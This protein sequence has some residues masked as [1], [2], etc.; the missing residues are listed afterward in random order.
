MSPL[1]ERVDPPWTSPEYAL[2]QIH[3]RLQVNG[4]LQTS[5]ADVYAI[6]DIAAFPNPRYGGKVGRQEHVQNARESAKHAVT[7]IM[8]PEEA[9]DYDYLPVRLRV[10]VD[11]LAP[12]NYPIPSCILVEWI[13]DAC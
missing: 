10:W 11:M 3:Q 6:G 4:Q 5:D 1:P 8:G 13:L 9:G 12:C 2:T 7:A